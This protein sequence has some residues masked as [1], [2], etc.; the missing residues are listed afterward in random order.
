[1]AV[2]LSTILDWRPRTPF[3]YGWLVLGLSGAGAFAATAIAGV[4]LG[5]VQPYILDDTNWS[6]T[7]I[8]LAA[9]MR[10]VA[11][12]ILR[13]LRR[14]GWPT[15]TDPAWLMPVGAHCPRRVE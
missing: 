8:G 6:R 7:S 10:G 13:P 14:A 1:M 11:V 5:G 2:Y 4:V 9:G 12:G 3:Y 15:G